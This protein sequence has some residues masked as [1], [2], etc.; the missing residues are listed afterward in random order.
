MNVLSSLLASCAQDRLTASSR[1]LRAKSSV[2]GLCLTGLA[3]LL[4]QPQELIQ[5][6]ESLQC[7]QNKSLVCP[8][9]EARNNWQRWLHPSGA[10]AVI[11]ADPFAELCVLTGLSC[12]QHTPKGLPLFWLLNHITLILST[13]ISCETKESQKVPEHV[14]PSLL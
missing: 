8:S 6:Q 14:S 1:I 11:R 5:F 7:S 2:P 3:S 10:H 4:R 13:R 12:T 9:W